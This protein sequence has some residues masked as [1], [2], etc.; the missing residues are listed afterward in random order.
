MTVFI[1]VEKL[2]YGIALNKR[3]EEVLI[4][5]LCEPL[6]ET[7]N[8]SKTTRFETE[9]KT[10]EETSFIKCYRNNRHLKYENGFKD[11]QF[12]GVLDGYNSKIEKILSPTYKNNVDEFLAR[13]NSISVY[14]NLKKFKSGPEHFINYIKKLSLCHE[15][16]ALFEMCDRKDAYDDYLEQNLQY[17][18]VLKQNLKEGDSVLILDPGLWLLPG[19]LEK[20]N[21]SC[22]TVFQIPIPRYEFFRCLY[23]NQTI[24][25][26]LNKSKLIFQ[27]KKE[28]LTFRYVCE[29]NFPNFQQKRLE[30][31]VVPLSTNLFVEEVE[32][33]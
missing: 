16:S 19:L 10:E 32:N 31:A 12:V 29:M 33:E 17:Y 11:V 15:W 3:K 27:N 21:I 1:V 4:D 7:I 5:K 8:E 9:L 6:I 20:E 28:E 26:S 2:Q 13:K 14:L 23:N 18:D 24:L 30:T 25:R 22:T